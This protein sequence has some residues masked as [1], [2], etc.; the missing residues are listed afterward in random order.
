MKTRFVLLLSIALCFAVSC[1]KP[2]AERR[3]RIPSMGLVFALGDSLDASINH[4]VYE[5]L[6][7]MLR[8]YKG[9][10][11]GAPD[12]SYGP[13]FS[14]KIVEPGS[15]QGNRAELLRS[16]ARQGHDIVVAIGYLFSDSIM[17]ITRE[18]PD[19]NFVLLDGSAPDLDKNSN[20]LCISFEEQEGSFIVGAYAAMYAQARSQEQEQRIAF[21]GAM[22]SP[23]TRRYYSGFAAGAAYVN[24][25]FRAPGSILSAYVAKDSS[26]FYDKVKAST[27]ASVLYKEGHASVIYGVAGTAGPAMA[28]VAN[29]L[30]AKLIGSDIDLKAYLSSSSAEQKNASAIIASML[31][32]ADRAIYAMA[33]VLF[34]REPFVGGYKVYNLADAGLGYISDIISEEDM[35]KLSALS[36]QIATGSIVVPEGEE[37]LQKFIANLQK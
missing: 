14:I 34:G 1:S 30:G 35:F 20:L 15:Q 21:I 24:R 4:S 29:R 16:L 33:P 2:A 7:N 13:D 3:D 18:F 19:V 22:D 10:I 11:E 31:K 26:G 27:L 12:R 32:R 28:E 37:A 9:H 17:A 36:K 25:A 23:N 5:G 6:L 8:D